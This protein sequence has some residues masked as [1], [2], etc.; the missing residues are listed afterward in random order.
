MR[1]IKYLTADH[2]TLSCEGEDGRII[3]LDRGSQAFAAAEAANPAPYVAPPTP[4]LTIE[5]YRRAVQSHTD[6]TAQSRGY[7]SGVTCAVHAT[8]TNPQWAAEGAAFIAWRD[9]VWSQVFAMLAN[10]P[11]PQPS[12]A[13]L[14][15]QLPE[16]EWP[17]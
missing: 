17:N 16:I 7:D 13:E 3:V 11:A 8:S 6:A 1:D 10:P 5:D 14:V 12:P 9:S 2:N 15:A 4:P